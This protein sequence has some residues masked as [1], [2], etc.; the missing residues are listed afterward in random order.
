MEP[1]EGLRPSQ[2][3]EYKEKAVFDLFDKNGDGSISASELGKVLRAM[4]QNPTEKMI[5]ETL[6]K[7][8]KDGDHVIE[9]EEYLEMLKDFRKDPQI[10][11]IELREAFRVFDKDR[12][13]NLNFAELRRALMHLGEPLTDKEAS[14]LCNM[15]D[16]NGD[17]KVDVEE[18][19]KYMCKTY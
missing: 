16:A 17:N 18:F 10:L 5:E 19:V 12:N 15:M 8:D 6:K 14:D 7:F 1:S 11:E 2:Y 9:Y 3:D 13:N 4:G